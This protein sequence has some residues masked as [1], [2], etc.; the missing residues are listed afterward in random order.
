VIRRRAAAALAIVACVFAACGQSS[1]G[2]AAG[3]RT[4]TVAPNLVPPSLHQGQLG[5]YEYA[6]AA[7][8]FAKAGPKSLVADGKLWE[9][10]RSARLVGTIQIATLRPKVKVGSARD[11][12]AI[13]AQLMPGQLTKLAVG[14]TEVFSSAAPDKTTYLWFGNQLFELLQL[15]TTAGTQLDATS[16]EDVLRELI[17]FQEQTKQLDIPSDRQTKTTRVRDDDAE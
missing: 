10:R 11:R 6:K 17:E 12:S 7:K 8:G 3:T 9:V 14:G 16:A 2:V 13:V 5:T 1:D 15:K 4:P